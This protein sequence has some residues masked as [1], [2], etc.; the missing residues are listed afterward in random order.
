MSKEYTI[1][2]IKAIG[3]AGG[4]TV[5]WIKKNG[6]KLT[7]FTEEEVN[8]IILGFLLNDKPPCEHLY[9]LDNHMEKESQQ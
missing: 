8:E 2:D 4:K 5:R 7:D 3:E 1:E 6:R 9:N